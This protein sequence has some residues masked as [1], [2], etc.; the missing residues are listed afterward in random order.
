MC[1]AKAPPCSPHRCQ[2]SVLFTQP[3]HP[4]CFPFLFLATDFKGQ[5]EAHFTSAVKHGSWL[6]KRVFK[7]PS[8]SQ[9]P[10]CASKH[11]GFLQTRF[12]SSQTKQSFPT[13]PLPAIHQQRGTLDLIIFQCPHPPNPP[14][15]IPQ[16]PL[17]DTA[18]N[19]GVRSAS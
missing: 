18:R 13:T 17:S 7:R 19:V 15:P 16:P 2:A 14:S 5:Q 9:T 1:P 4:L 12:H 11:K 10:R 8:V 3:P 6:C